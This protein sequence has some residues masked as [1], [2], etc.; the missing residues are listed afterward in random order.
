MVSQVGTLDEG[1]DEVEQAISVP[2]SITRIDS[3]RKVVVE[4]GCG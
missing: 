2:V 4:K 3:K 1:S